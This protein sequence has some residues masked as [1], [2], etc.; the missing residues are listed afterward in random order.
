MGMSDALSQRW[1]T[2]NA[3]FL[4]G[5]RLAA[6]WSGFFSTGIKTIRFVLQSAMLAIG[7]WLV[8]RRRYRQG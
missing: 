7:A 1:N 6:D 2:E 8:I 4:A 5:Q 3:T